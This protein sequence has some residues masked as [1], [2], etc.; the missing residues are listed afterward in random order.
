MSPQMVWRFTDEDDV[1]QVSLASNFVSL[2]TKAY[3]SREDFFTRLDAVVAALAEH[4]DPRTVDRIGVRYIDRITGDMLGRVN[5]LIRP[6]IQGVSATTVEEFTQHSLSD[7]LFTVPNTSAQLLAR[8][9]FLPKDVTVDP[10]AVE[11]LSTPSWILDLD[12]FRNDPRSFIPE[13]AAA[14]ARSFAER[15]YTFFRWIVTDDFLRLYG[16]DQ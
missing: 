8:W 10:A 4:V 15:I 11:V 12:M 1:W 3:V 16:G 6:E 9:G 2:D 13:E 5:S 7:N 14:E